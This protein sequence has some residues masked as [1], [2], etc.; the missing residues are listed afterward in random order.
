MTNTTKALKNIP[1]LTGPKSASIGIPLSDP[2]LNFCE[3]LV[4]ISKLHNIVNV[5]IVHQFLLCKM[6]SERKDFN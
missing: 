4:F 6:G 1:N 5:H 2:N 3:N